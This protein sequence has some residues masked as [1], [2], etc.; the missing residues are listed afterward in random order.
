M[1][2]AGV[3]SEVSSVL[4]GVHFNPPQLEKALQPRGFFPFVEATPSEY[5]S[6]NIH[7]IYYRH[8]P[9]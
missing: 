6:P 2:L 3:N 8:V 9:S 1:N 7:V 4:N 5:I